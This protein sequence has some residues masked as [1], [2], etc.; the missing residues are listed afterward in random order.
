VARSTA[1]YLD[2]THPEANK[3]MVAREAS[4]I[5]RIPLEQIATIGDMANDV[6]MLSVA[7]RGIAMGNAGPEVQKAA[8]HVTLSNEE[9]GFAHAIDAFILGQPPLGGTALGLPPRARACLLELDGVVAQLSGQDAQA[10]KQLFDE[11]LQERARAVGEP[12]VPFD[13]VGHYAFH[14]ENTPPFQGV[15]SFLASRGIELPDDTVRALIDRQ[16]EILV[17]RLRRERLETYEETLRYLR[18]ARET[19][20]RTAVL[21][22]KPHGREI[23]ESAVSPTSS[24]HASTAP[25]RPRS[26]SWGIRRPTRASPPR[27]RSASTPNRRSSSM[28]PSPASKRAAPATSATWSASIAGAPPPSFAVTA[29]TSWSP[30]WAR[31]SRQRDSN[32][33]RRG[34]RLRLWSALRGS[35]GSPFAEGLS[36]LQPEL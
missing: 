6:P 23:L 10:W 12:F 24:M 34:S 30:I 16:G 4:R 32:G 7:G 2:V 19:G 5:F 8:R 18:A 13:L 3:G 28:T 20:F 29:R 11:Y 33:P 14:L 35:D 27:V 15:R 22:S 31:S 21:S 1:F 26:T 36:D 9:E 25:S 17:E